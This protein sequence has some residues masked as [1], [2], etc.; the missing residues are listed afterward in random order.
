MFCRER[1]MCGFVHKDDFV[2]DSKQC[3]WTESQLNEERNLRR[4]AVLGLDDCKGDDDNDK[5][6]AI[7]SHQGEEI[8]IRKNLRFVV[9]AVVLWQPLVLSPGARTLYSFLVRLLHIVECPSG[10]VFHFQFSEQV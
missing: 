4:K 1:K 7:P 6:V 3:A 9:Y 2:E 10:R 8:E 5:A